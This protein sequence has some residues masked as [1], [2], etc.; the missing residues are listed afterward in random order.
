MNTTATTAQPPS[1]VQLTTLA[2]YYCLI[3]FFGFVSLQAL[4]S[5]R[6]TTLVIWV[7]QIL[8][9]LPFAPGL[10]RRN[11]RICLWLSLLVLLYFIH[12]VQVA[13]D[14]ARQLQGI[15]E[16][17]LCLLLFSSLMWTIRIAN[18]QE[19]TYEVMTEAEQHRSDSV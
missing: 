13:F 14:P 2:L 3:A 16:A 5:V 6:F 7:L 19:R 17:V 4:D 1:I 15:I 9:L 12:G 11:K 18:K 8:P 10:H